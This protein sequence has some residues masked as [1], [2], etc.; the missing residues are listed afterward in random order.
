M[1]FSPKSH[2]ADTY[3]EGPRAPLA[4]HTEHGLHTTPFYPA[5][6]LLG[7]QI[8]FHVSPI[9]IRV[10][11]VT[12]ST[13]PQ[14]LNNTY[15]SPTVPGLEVQEQGVRRLAVWRA[16]ALCCLHVV[17]GGACSALRTE[18][19]APLPDSTIMRIG[20]DHEFWIGN[21]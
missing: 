11:A 1:G 20:F 9:F 8:V 18:S 6:L 17:R 15:L 21:R 16:H 14:L 13:G 2:T 12:Q 10:A 19:K 5:F 4:H 7:V 3:S